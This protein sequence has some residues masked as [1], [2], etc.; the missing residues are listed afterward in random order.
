MK[1]N[2]VTADKKRE[3]QLKN[4]YFN[5]YLL[6]RYSLA[7][8]F[9]ANLY[10][11]LGLLPEFNALVIFPLSLMLIIILASA[12]QFRMYGTWVSYLTTTSYAFI[13]QMLVNIGLVL[14]LLFSNQASLISPVFASTEAAKL[15]L[16]GI[17]VIGIFLAIF[18]LYR[19]R[20]IKE[21][22]DSFYRRFQNIEKY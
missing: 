22:R 1:K 5:R 7:G 17:Q 19:I 11:L 12:E 10:W 15:L 6:L 16:V 8:F 4:T 3:Y 20:Q 14:F 2:Y 9:F 13:G 21:N 18:N